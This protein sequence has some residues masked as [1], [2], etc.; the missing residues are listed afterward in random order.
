MGQYFITD[1]LRSYDYSNT[2]LMIFIVKVYTGLG[3]YQVR[4]CHLSA[5]MYQLMT[6][7]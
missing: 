2:T 3:L 1:L 7:S 6:I 4:Y 5:C